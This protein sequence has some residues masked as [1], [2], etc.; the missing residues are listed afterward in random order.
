MNENFYRAFLAIIVIPYALM[1]LVLLWNVAGPFIRSRL[2][3]DADR[4]KL[5][6]PNWKSGPGAGE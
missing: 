2:L 1:F 4:D 5:T 6:S 3:R